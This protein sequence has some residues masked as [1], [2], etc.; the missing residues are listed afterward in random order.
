MWMNRVRQPVTRIVTALPRLAT[1]RA[2]RPVIPSWRR[3]ASS[4]REA[5]KDSTSNWFRNSLGFALAGT[6]VF[7]LYTYATLDINKDGG[8][9]NAK[10]KDLLPG[11]ADDPGTLF[12][13]K[14]RSLRSPGVYLWGTN[15]YKVADPDSKETVIKTPRHLSY[16]DG[17]VLRDLKLDEKSGA[18]ITE[19]GELIQWGKG[20]SESDFKPT[21]TLTGKNLTSLCMSQD[22]ILALSSDGK[23][24]SLPISKNDQQSGRKPRDGSW[25]PFRSGGNADVSFRVLQPKLGMTERVTA[26]SGGQEH[27]LL[28]TNSGRVFSVASSTENYPIFGQLGIP[29]LTWSTRPEGPADTCHEV[30]ALKG[31]KITQVATGDY[32]S[33]ALS[34]DSQVFAFGDNSF[35]QLGVGFNS[36]TPFIDKPILLPV[37]KLY[38]NNEWAAKVMQI[39]AGGANSFFSVDAQRIAG[40]DEDPSA[41]SDLGR[42]RADIWTCGRGIW[43]LL[44]NGKWTHM[45][46]A[47]TKLK[48]L[49]GLCEFDER[50]EKVSPI[51]LR[52]I[53]VGTTHASAVLDNNTHLHSASSKAL[54]TG[55]DWGYD[56]LWWGGNEHFQL[57]TGKR[58]NKSRPTYIN[59]PP[60]PEEKGNKQEARLQIMPRHK[61]Q[62]GNRTVNME[63]RIECGR[64]VSGI[65]SSA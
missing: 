43:G 50:T 15:M 11:I 39:A 61:G 6:G 51:H 31:S 45:Q 59:A 17:Q 8:P 64:H 21:Q 65:Y 32:H 26:V 28:L 55:D 13:Q 42:I 23:V 40:S 12:V 37:N 46:D 53:S 3:Y 24:Y 60:G 36:S 7:L 10:T 29:G 41:V 62:A 30:T 52:D 38:R 2:C 20:F 56:A 44:G 48:A 1:T 58:N 54:E 22:R 47:P 4:D 63:Q 34:K 49:S 18:A 5:P 57:G 9:A 19:K 27:A 16:F 25:V 33:L 35:G 14:K